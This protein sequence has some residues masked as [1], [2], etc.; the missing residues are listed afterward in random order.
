MKRARQAADTGHQNAQITISDLKDIKDRLTKLEK[1][2]IKTNQD[3]LKTN[4]DLR[5]DRILW[6][7]DQLSN[8]A[9][10]ILL[11]WSNEQP[12]EFAPGTVP[13]NRFEDMARSKSEYFASLCDGLKVSAEQQEEVGRRFDEV[14]NRRN[15]LIHFGSWS[16]LTKRVAAIQ[17]ILEEA[18]KLSEGFDEEV[19]IIQAFGVFRSKHIKN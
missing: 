8:L 6:A 19:K 12:K 13:L 5:S 15:V 7:P 4:Q 9:T 1:S 16:V 2:S 14:V 17:R 10:N 11:F 3:L 18:P